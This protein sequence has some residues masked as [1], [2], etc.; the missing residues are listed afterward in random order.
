M[1]RTTKGYWATVNPLVVHG[2]CDQ[3]Y[4]KKIMKIKNIIFDWA[5]VINDSIHNVY[6]VAMLVFEHYGVKRLTLDEFRESWDQPYMV[7]YE[8]FIP[9]IT[10][11]EETKIYKREIMKC[12]PNIPFP[13]SIE[14]LHFLK[15]SGKNMIIYSGDIKET[16]F[17]EIKRFGA[18]NIFS[19]V[20]HDVH[21]KFQFVEEILKRNEFDRSK[22]IFIGDTTHEIEV[23]KKAG[24]LTGA[25]T[26]GYMS[27]SRLK[28]Y[29]PDYLFTEMDQLKQLA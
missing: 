13:G 11:E 24:I 28:T 10:L 19:E 22:T 18:E 7:F 8:K 20:N 2:G 3:G 21:D 16:I 4:C 27:E 9:G 5:G 15:D 17:E 12:P 6:N 14:M 25:V 26:W 29:S 1:P 23:G